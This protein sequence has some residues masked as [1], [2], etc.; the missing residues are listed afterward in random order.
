M[1]VSSADA[2]LEPGPERTTGWGEMGVGDV[3]VKRVGEGLETL[4]RSR[5]VG[6]IGRPQGDVGEESRIRQIGPG[7]TGLHSSARGSPL[8]YQ[9]QLRENGVMRLQFV[10]TA[11]LLITAALHCETGDVQPQTRRL[12]ADLEFLTSRA[13]AGRVSLSPEAE[14]AARYIAADFART[15]LR[16]PAGN[17][18]L[19]E[20]PLVAYRGDSAS[21]PPD[22]VQIILH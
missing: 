4:N 3:Q 14:I 17:S 21:S 6:Q 1:A 7:A 13:L 5:Q 15:G 20:F 22:L 11:L 19:Q 10:P 16:P 9:G 18:Y 8:V 2:G 12:R